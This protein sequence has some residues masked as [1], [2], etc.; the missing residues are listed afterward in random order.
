MQDSPRPA[1]ACHIF[2]TTPIRRPCGLR[3]GGQGHL[4]VTS[5]DAYLLGFAGESAGL[6]MNLQTL[7]DTFGG[8]GNEAYA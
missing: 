7:A 4:L 3:F 2:T 5:M 8:G 1:G 6:H